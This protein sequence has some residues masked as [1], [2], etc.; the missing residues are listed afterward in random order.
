ME[1]HSPLAGGSG[2]GHRGRAQR[3]A[4]HLVG[5]WTGRGLIGTL[6]AALVRAVN[7]TTPMI[8][9]EINFQHIILL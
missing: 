3:T 4:A 1:Q 8:T 9:M 6:T 2:L 7:V 5:S